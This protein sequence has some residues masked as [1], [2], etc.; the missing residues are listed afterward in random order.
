M[1]YSKFLKN[2]RVVLVG[3]SWHLKNEKQGD[4]IDAYDI[5]VRMNLGYRIPAK[6]IVNMGKR[7]DI[8]YSTIGDLYIKDK[9]FTNKIMKK[10]S[11]SLKWFC[12]TSHPLHRK[13]FNALEKM[14]K[15][16]NIPT[17][18][19]DNDDYKK[20]RKKTGKKLTCGIVTIS[21]LLR[22][23]ISEL[24]VTGLTFYDTKVIDKRV[25]YYS[26]Y[27]KKPLV[28][29]NRPFGGHNLTAELNIFKKIKKRDKRVKCDTVLTE[30]LKQDKILTKKKGVK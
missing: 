6:L 13:S 21:D 9:Y 16:A 30:I 19:T 27:R 10:L 24:Y 4:I 15:L 2:K 14:N 20:I 8:L 11:S 12:I 3:P 18:Q 28:Y 22:Y 29:S 23:D 7:I 17:R 26:N 5:V 1:K 25:I